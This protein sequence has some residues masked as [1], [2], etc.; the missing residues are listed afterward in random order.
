MY[1][2]IIG[3]LINLIFFCLP[4]YYI[5]SFTLLFLVQLIIPSYW[6][7]QMKIISLFFI[8]R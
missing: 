7:L 4:D 6:C 1:S 3:K 2:K 8:V 5:Y